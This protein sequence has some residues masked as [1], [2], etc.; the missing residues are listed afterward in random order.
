MALSTFTVNGKSIRRGLEV[1]CQ[2]AGGGLER[3]H[4]ATHNKPRELRIDME[5]LSGNKVYAHYTSF[6][7]ALESDK[8]AITVSGY[9]GT[10][11]YDALISPS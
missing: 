1:R 5:D 10:A 7:I 4:A 2:N 3:L 9:S 8:Y 6:G 11:G